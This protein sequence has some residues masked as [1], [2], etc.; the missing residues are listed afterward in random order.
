[1]ISSLLTGDA[2]G[3]S[4]L[5][6]RHRYEA[7]RKSAYMYAADFK[8]SIKAF[9]EPGTSEKEEPPDSLPDR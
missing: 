8:L 7:L 6:E 3:L 9:E 4:F 1:M 5:Y 2:E